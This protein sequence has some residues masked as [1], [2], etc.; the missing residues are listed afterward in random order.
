MSKIWLT[1]DTHFSHKNTLRYDG[2]PFFTVKSH[3]ESLI[4]RWN[5]VVSKDDFVYHLGDVTMRWQN[6]KRI[7]PRL[8]GTIILIVGNHDLIFPYFE[9]TRGKKFV[10]DM[11]KKYLEAGF[12]AIFES[13]Y[14]LAVGYELTVNEQKQKLTNTVVRLSHFPTKNAYDKGHQDKHT[15]CKPEDTGILN[16]CGHVHRAWLKHGN[17]INVGGPCWDYTP[18]ALEDV[19]KLHIYGKDVIPAPNKIRTFLWKVY[20]TIVYKFYRV[21]GVDLR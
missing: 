13:G 6:L 4:K 1:S 19:I 17:N 16:I 11:H 12:S 10:E 2:R 5:S 15:L 21:T 14:K 9:K 18:V 7:I 20:H 3:D 8:N